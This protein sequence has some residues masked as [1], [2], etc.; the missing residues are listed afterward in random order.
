MK[1]NFI[2][3]VHNQAASVQFYKT[4]LGQEP[5][6]DVPGMAEFQLSTE[7]VL[8]LMPEKGIKAASWKCN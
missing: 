2:F 8:G 6:L 4:V 5:I 7:S 1:C 3:Y